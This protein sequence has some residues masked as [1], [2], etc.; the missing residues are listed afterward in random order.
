ML[1]ARQSPGY[2]GA[3]TAA[4]GQRS[5]SRCFLS[6]MLSYD[7]QMRSCCG[8]NL[9]K[10][11]TSMTQSICMDH[12]RPENWAVFR[13]L[14]TGTHVWVPVF[15]TTCRNDDDVV[16]KYWFHPEGRE[17]GDRNY[18]INARHSTQRRG[19]VSSAA[20]RAWQGLCFTKQT[21]DYYLFVARI[22]EMVIL[23]YILWHVTQ[24]SQKQ[25]KSGYWFNNLCSLCGNKPKLIRRSGSMQFLEK[26]F[27]HQMLRESYSLLSSKWFLPTTLS[28]KHF[29]RKP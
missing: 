25:T 19:N 24:P 9:W 20:L 23:W 7:F 14:V 15:S 10:S 2:W 3:D 27:K 12:L 16:D 18:D 8:H 6:E 11:G 17:A 28:V 4:G 5:Q 13:E 1:T 22:R 26:Y 21:G 29:R